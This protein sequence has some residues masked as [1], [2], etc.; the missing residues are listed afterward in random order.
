ME[1]SRDL[2]MDF[3]M[4]DRRIWEIDLTLRGANLQLLLHELGPAMRN[5]E[6]AFRVVWA[7]LEMIKEQLSAQ[8]R[9]H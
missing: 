5:L 6:V 2:A 9:V 7:K 1:A 4:M 3:D 8:Q